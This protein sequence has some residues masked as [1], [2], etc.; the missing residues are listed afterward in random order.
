MSLSNPFKHQTHEPKKEKPAQ[1]DLFKDYFRG[2][3][4]KPDCDW[5]WDSW[6]PVN[7][8][9]VFTEGKQGKEV[10]KFFNKE[11]TDCN[12]PEPDSISFVLLAF[13]TLLFIKRKFAL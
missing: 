7:G 5:D 2:D 8:N 9:Y 6:H 11:V 3:K 12:V 10:F 13:V 4:G 1:Y